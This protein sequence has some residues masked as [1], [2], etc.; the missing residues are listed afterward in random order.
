MALCIGRLG[1]MF[2]KPPLF[3][4]VLLYVYS[5]IQ[6][7]FLT[8]GEKGSEEWKIA[9][10]TVALVLKC[11]LFLYVTYLYQSGRLLFYFVRVRRVHENWDEE[12]KNFSSLLT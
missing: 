5:S 4:L 12:W 10:M 1:S 6:A 2:L 8:F 9:L 3:V 11:L 7:L